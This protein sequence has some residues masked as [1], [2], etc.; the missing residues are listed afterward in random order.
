MT[1][2][3]SRTMIRNEIWTVVNSSHSF[4]RVKMF[5]KL[6]LE[7]TL[8]NFGLG[9]G[10]GAKALFDEM[11]ASATLLILF[12]RNRTER[13]ENR[14]QIRLATLIRTDNSYSSIS[15]RIPTPINVAKCKKSVRAVWRLATGLSLPLQSRGAAAT[16]CHGA[17]QRRQLFSRAG[18]LTC[19]IFGKLESVRRDSLF[20]I[21]FIKFP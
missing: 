16:A 8:D 9:T 6:N 20:T 3:V 11:R 14:W 21:E 10:E 12:G 18:I 7:S 15:L 19:F 2:D 13:N 17:G 4:G 1:L 5:L